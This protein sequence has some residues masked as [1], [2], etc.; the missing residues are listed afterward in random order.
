MRAVLFICGLGVA[1]MQSAL[2]ARAQRVLLRADVAQDTLQASSGPNRTYFSH[3]YLG[4]TAVVGRASGPGADLLFGRSGEF[5]VGIRNKYRLSQALAVGLDLR[6][7]RLGYYLEQNDRKAV[8]TTTRYAREH[9]SLS[10]VQGEAFLRLNAGRRGNAI[11]HYLDLLGW[12]G[13]VM[14]SSHYYQEA[15]TATIK[16]RQ[17]T[18]R[19][20]SYMQRW[21]YGVGARLGSGRLAVVGRYRLSSTFTGAA[22][23][24]YPELPRWLLGLEL[25]WF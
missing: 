20:L 7:A 11:G 14:G 4:Y 25:G 18:E 9:L 3:F 21:P 8:P 16:K 1:L 22:Q 5:Q 23:D 6:Y 13:W 2:P 10:Q 15:A 17:T 19:G 24:R 12:A